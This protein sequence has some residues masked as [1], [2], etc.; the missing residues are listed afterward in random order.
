MAARLGA[1]DVDR[2]LH[3]VVLG[4][5]AQ[6]V[7][8]VTRDAGPHQHEVD[9]G[10]HRT[11]GGG[12][13]GH[14]QLLEVVDADQAV[15][16]LLGQP[17]LGEVAQDRQLLRCRGL[18]HGEPGHGAVR[19]ARGSPI[20]LEVARDGAS[21][22]RGHRECRERAT[23]RTVPVA[24]LEPTGQDHVQRGARDDAELSRPRDRRGQPPG[25][26]GHAHPA[27]DH[28]GQRTV[29]GPGRAGW[30]GHE[31]HQG[32]LSLPTEA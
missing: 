30:C 21:S 26:H 8:D 32:S 20:R 2:E 31:S 16:T 3:D 4:Q 7:R 28:Q 14:P 25:R 23:R 19:S 27:L 17:D 29:T 11:V 18:V 5:L 13:G 9:P 15:V 24:V 22:D 1:G 6:Q 12:R 10:E